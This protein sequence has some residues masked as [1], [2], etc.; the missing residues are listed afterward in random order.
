MTSK[1]KKLIEEL[2]SIC[3][4]YNWHDLTSMRFALDNTKHFIKKNFLSDERSSEW[5]IEQFNRNRPQEEQVS[6][7]ED[8]EK[9]VDEIFNS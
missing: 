5:R 1:E 9:K 6:T 2:Y 7:I 3:N 8:M 4:H